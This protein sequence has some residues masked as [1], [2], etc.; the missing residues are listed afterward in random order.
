M[1]LESNSDRIRVLKIKIFSQMG[2]ITVKFLING[3]NYDQ[4]IKR[5]KENFKE[6]KARVRLYKSG[7]NWVKAGIR[8]IQL[9]K[10]MGLPFAGQ[11][12]AVGKDLNSQNSSFKNNAL[13]RQ[14]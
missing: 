13:K 2:N 12:V 6:E 14:L 11:K 4:K 5:F 1:L 8:E 7:K 3:G 10:V 9:M